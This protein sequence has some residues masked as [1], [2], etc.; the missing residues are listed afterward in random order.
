MVRGV[1]LKAGRQKYVVA[2]PYLENNLF[3]SQ[4]RWKNEHTYLSH[5]SVA[6][7]LYVRFKF[8]LMRTAPLLFNILLLIEVII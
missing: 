3:A 2:L 4:K 7:E 5:L 8:S 6:H 1:Y